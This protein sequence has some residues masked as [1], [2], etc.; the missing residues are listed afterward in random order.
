MFI[1]KKLP[2]IWAKL[3]AKQSTKMPP[4]N[5][6]QPITS[7]FKPKTKQVIDE[8]GEAA[9]VK[10]S[11]EKFNRVPVKR[12]A[13]DDTHPR[14]LNGLTPPKALKISDDPDNKKQ[15]KGLLSPQVN[16]NQG[17]LT[18]TRSV[19]KKK[20]S[21]GAYALH[22][23]IGKSWFRALQ[24]EFDKPYFKK[25]SAFV[26]EQRQN[27]T[28][29]PPEHKVYTWTRF[30]D[31]NDTRV[32]ILGQ[33][34]YHGPNQAHGLSFSVQSGVKLP[35]SLINIFKELENDIAGF[36]SPSSG[37]LTGWA[38]QGVLML[39]ACLSVN[40][41]QANSHQNKGW[42]IFTDA[43]IS[44]LSKNTKHN[45][46]FLLWGRPAQ[47]KTTLIDKRH[48]VLTAAHPSPLSAHNGFF[49]CAH[50]SQT[51]QYLKSQNLP[52]IDWKAL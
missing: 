26:K 27:N 47:R 15:I 23:N 20:I 45:L 11:L 32:V 36:K 2:T 16:L 38:K 50:F 1:L 7:F 12:L 13:E 37:D 10:Q 28:V 4:P 44:W 41:G 24:S 18:D 21:S 30:H 52:E 9:D 43:V 8:D 49:G 25:L 31:I 6:Q 48:K 29:F 51:N 5:R 35:P 22:E 34:P 39:N 14:D 17:C 19:I 42:E 46:V 33:D 3:L 40:Q